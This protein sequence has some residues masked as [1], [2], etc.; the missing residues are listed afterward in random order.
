MVMAAHAR[1]GSIELVKRQST[2]DPDSY[3]VLFRPRGVDRLIQL[4]RVS[5]WHDITG[6]IAKVKQEAN[7]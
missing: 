6:D 5:Q 4:D 3:V 1:R 7:P 2:E